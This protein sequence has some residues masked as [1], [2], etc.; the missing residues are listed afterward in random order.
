MVKPYCFFEPAD[1]RGPSFRYHCSNSGLHYLLP[2]LFHVF[3]LQQKHQLALSLLFW[4]NRNPP[5]STELLSTYFREV[6]T[7][8]HMP[9]TINEQEIMELFIWCFGN[10]K[11]KQTLVC[12]QISRRC[13][14]RWSMV[15]LNLL[16]GRLLS[17]EGI[18]AYSKLISGLSTMTQGVTE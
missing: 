1:H 10:F 12:S 16:E 18:G 3:L 11:N 8:S 6:T 4:K 7:C 2:E 13:E 15:S 17:H 9:M 14:D 5:V